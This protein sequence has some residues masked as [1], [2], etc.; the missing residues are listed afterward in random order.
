MARIAPGK[1][2]VAISE[3]KQLYADFNPG[4]PL[5][6]EFL[7]QEYQAQYLAEQRVESFSAYFAFL[8]IF[9]SC[10]G[11]F[12]LA[13]FNAE[14]RIKEIGIRKVLGESITN[15]ITLLS[16]DFIKLVLVAFFIGMPVAYYFSSRWL[17][18]FAYHV[19]IQWW[20]FA[21]AGFLIL[22]VSLVIVCAQ[23]LRT[24]IVNP[25]EALKSE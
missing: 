6:Y 2:K 23:S 21:S 20:M 12:G 16:K 22:G 9:L 14:T 7:D 10:F 8:T 13:I 5:D 15:I 19:E 17:Q 4:F 24:V 11:L 18:N 25:V 3:L 1:V